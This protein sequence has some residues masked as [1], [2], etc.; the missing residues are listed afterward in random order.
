MLLME[1]EEL[2]HVV[3]V[4]VH[5]TPFMWLNLLRAWVPVLMLKSERGP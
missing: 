3:G 2:H 4:C 1:E 5:V